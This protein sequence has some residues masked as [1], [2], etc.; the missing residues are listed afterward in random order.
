MQPS[1]W[2]LTE[3]QWWL[4]KHKV[5]IY[6]EW[7]RLRRSGREPVALAVPRW[8]DV[9]DGDMALGLPLVRGGDEW[10]FRL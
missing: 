9:H 5:E 10:E 7:D 3:V 2:M 1:D 8:L 4:V 6:Q